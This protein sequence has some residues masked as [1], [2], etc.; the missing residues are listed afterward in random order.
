M[1]AIAEEANECDKKESSEN[2]ETTSWKLSRDEE[3]GEEVWDENRK[4]RPQVLRPP[5]L[6]RRDIAVIVSATVPTVQCATCGEEGTGAKSRGLG[7]MGG[8]R[9]NARHSQFTGNQRR[10]CFVAVQGDEHR[11]HRLFLVVIEEL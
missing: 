11:M 8:N 6:Y 5:N 9:R 7:R 4:E 2:A 1:V 3:R 10:E